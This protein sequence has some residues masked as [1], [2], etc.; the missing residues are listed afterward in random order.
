MIDSQLSSD[1]GNEDKDS[2]NNSTTGIH[3]PTNNDNVLIEEKAVDA[4]FKLS[5]KN[6]L[7]FISNDKDNSEDNRKIFVRIQE[8]NLR[9][10]NKY[11]RRLVYL[12]SCR[13]VP[14]L[15]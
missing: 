7:V 5:S 6:W 10:I 12:W 9:R 11:K 15:V 8:A 3:G 13:S 2:N 4:C 14:N 1:V